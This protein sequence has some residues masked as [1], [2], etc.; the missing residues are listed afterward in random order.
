MIKRSICDCTQGAGW[1]GISR[2][3]CVGV[4]VP[5]QLITMLVLHAETVAT[6]SLHLLD[7]T[8][9]ARRA[10]NKHSQDNPNEAASRSRLDGLN[11]DSGTLVCRRQ[12]ARGHHEPQ[13]TAA[14]AVTAFARS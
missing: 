14:A 9:V 4:L 5:W 7:V 2:D 13:H 12:G 8:P 1:H 6:E 11:K 3:S 10:G